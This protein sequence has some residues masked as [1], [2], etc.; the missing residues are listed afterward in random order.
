MRFYAARS[1]K[2]LRRVP[3]FCYHFTVLLHLRYYAG[4]T[5]C[6][7]RISSEWRRSCK[8]EVAAVLYPMKNW[9]PT[10]R[11][12]QGGNRRGPTHSTQGLWP[13]RHLIVTLILIAVLAASMSTADN[14]LHALSAVL[15]RD[16][17]QILRPEASEERWFGRGHHSGHHSRSLFVE[18]ETKPRFQ[19]IDANHQLMF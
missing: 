5:W 16:V 1:V 9:V 3:S 10:N 19:P 14:N 6:A 13:D 8:P 15:T 18:I 4:C 2:T 7:L 17:W 11:H 12:G